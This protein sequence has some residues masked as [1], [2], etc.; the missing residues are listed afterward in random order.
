MYQIGVSKKE[1]TPDL[2][3]CGMLGYGQ[4]TNVA[5]GIESPLYVRVFVIEKDN[6]KMA[7][8]NAEICFPTQSLKDGVIAQL[9]LK[10]KDWDHEN[11]MLTTQHTHSA[12]GGYTHYFIYN[13]T[14]PGFQQEILDSY[15]FGIADAILDAEKNKRAGR[16]FFEK[17]TFDEKVD[18]AFNRSLKPYNAN[19]EVKRKLKKNEWHLGVDRTMKLLRFEGEDG[20]PIGSINWFGVHTTSISND[21]TLI[22]SDNKGYAASYFEKE[23]NSQY[24]TNQEIITIFAQDTT[25]DVSP[26]FI[27]DKKKKWTR[28][29]FEDDFES[30]KQHGYFQ[31]EM[32]KSIFDKSLH[33]V[34]LKGP[35]DFINT[36]SDFSRI[37][38]KPAFA[39][40]LKHQRTSMPCLG[41]SFL[42]GTKEGPG[43]PKTV[44]VFAKGAIAT[45]KLYRKYV[46]SNFMSYRDKVEMMHTF[47]N[48]APK[49]A[50]IEMGTGHVMGTKRVRNLIIPAIADPI[51]MYFKELDR[52]G[53]TKNMPWG[54]QVLPLQFF[55]IG[56]MG[57][58]GQPSEI[59][60]IAGLRLKN[61]I[62]P[63]LNDIGIDE[64]M[65]CSYANAYAG[66]TTTQEEYQLQH[67]EGGHTLYGKWTLAAFQTEFEQLA[68]EFSKSPFTRF[69]KEMIDG[70]EQATPRSFNNDELWT[71]FKEEKFKIKV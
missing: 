64:L 6:R 14:V 56:Q 7:F 26:N 39:N 15:V 46:Y 31:Y 68:L 32:A 11:V 43:M 55:R 65:I 57:F 51:I 59:T 3:N 12:P 4:F 23:L 10:G 9:L 8:V 29:T 34:E 44:G 67:Y 21:N 30:A 38:V 20:I 48:Q 47:K 33:G 24:Q 60:T 17:D 35:I 41:V 25:G 61:T 52:K 13:I 19:P 28:G 50:I 49:A 18:I 42:E 45:V 22:S 58:L 27:W 62:L 5:K 16:I 66:Y 54:P 69:N 1:I 37:K 40:N 71:G 2:K 70:E 63:I 53:I 36:Y